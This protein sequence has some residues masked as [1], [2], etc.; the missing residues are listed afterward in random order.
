[1]SALKFNGSGGH[2]PQTEARR[3]VYHALAVTLREDIRHAEWLHDDLEHEPDRRRAM[4]AAE[5]ILRELERKAAG[6]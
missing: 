2:K 3:Y 1:M 5:A 4:K 6:R